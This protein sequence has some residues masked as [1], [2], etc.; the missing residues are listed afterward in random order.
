M[1]RKRM[2]SRFLFRPQPSAM[3][4]MIEIAAFRI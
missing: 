2:S 3:F 1:L 4:D